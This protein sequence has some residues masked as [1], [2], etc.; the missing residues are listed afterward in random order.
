MSPTALVL[1]QTKLEQ[2]AFWRNP[3]AAFYTFALP[4]ILLALVGATNDGSQS[5]AEF[6]PGIM[7]FG[8]IAA[9]F[10]NLAA[11]VATLRADGV[12]KRVRTTPLP[13]IIYLAGHLLC[14]VLTAL[15]ITGVLIVLGKLLFDAAPLRSG[16]P[17]LV[18]GIIIGI[19][20][21]ASLALAITSVIPSA[22]AA[23]PVT[24]VIYL[25]L[26]LVSGLFDAS[27]SLPPVAERIV[28]YL[29]VKPFANVLSAAYD[30]TIAD[31]F[32]QDL[33]VLSVWSL[34][35][36]VLTFRFFRWQPDV[37]ERGGV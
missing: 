24:N 30:S 19:V 5:G 31:S 26:A 23:G 27:L 10:A 2:V 28:N 17:V 3:D 13:P 36:M 16:L 35:G 34:L 1:Y 18:G 25:P 20:C 7:A 37:R 22:D 29:P 32:Y 9:A 8:V 14:S 21:F 15:L 4:I 6:V 33:S 11:R 12:L